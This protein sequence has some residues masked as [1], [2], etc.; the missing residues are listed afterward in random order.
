MYTHTYV[1]NL[2]ANLQICI[3]QLQVVELLSTIL[4]L[5]LILVSLNIFFIKI[6]QKIDH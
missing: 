5:K 6:I 1:H 3:L 4:Q 2:N